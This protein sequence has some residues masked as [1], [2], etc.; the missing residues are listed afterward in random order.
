MGKN[1]FPQRGM[2]SRAKSA[3]VKSGNRRRASNGLGSWPSK[4]PIIRHLHRFLG[5]DGEKQGGNGK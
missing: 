2:A 4:L 1:S 5:V 3:T